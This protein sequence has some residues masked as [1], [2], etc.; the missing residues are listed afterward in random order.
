MKLPILI[1]FFLILPFSYGNRAPS[2]APN[3]DKVTHYGYISVPSESGYKNMLYTRIFS[4][5][6]DYLNPYNYATSIRLQFW[7]KLEAQFI[8]ADYYNYIN[9]TYIHFF[10]SQSQAEYARKEDIEDHKLEYGDS[11]NI[12]VMLF[13]YENDID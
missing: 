12:K 2:L 7:K 8:N 5:K 10:D 13:S 6:G 4:F 11:G 9:A 1:I 3:P